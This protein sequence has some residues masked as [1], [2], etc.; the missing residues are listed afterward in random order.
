MNRYAQG[1]MSKRE[2]IRRIPH[3]YGALS[4]EYST[5]LRTY[6]LLQTRVLGHP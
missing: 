4:P 6:L 2:G 3:I 1:V 5:L